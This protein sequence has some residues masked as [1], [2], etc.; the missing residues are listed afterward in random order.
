M[1]RI[2]INGFGRIGR[3]VLRGILQREAEIEVVA[4][5]DLGDPATL[6]HL[7]AYDT[8]GGKPDR[9][10]SVERETL[11]VDGRRIAVLAEPDP[12]RLPWAHMERDIV[13]ES[14]GRFTKA[15]AA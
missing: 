11:V 9:R 5:N 4:I 6:A 12:P 3:H 14:I 13:L 10:V 7:L 1:T 8:T 2:A 15:T